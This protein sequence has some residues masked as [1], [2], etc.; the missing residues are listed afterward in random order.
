VWHTHCFL[1]LHRIRVL[2]VCAGLFFKLSDETAPKEES[3]HTTVRES[4]APK[5]QAG[6]SLA[7]Q[8]ES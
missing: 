7:T 6:L 5:T 1:A 8:V 3:A 2:P 4:G